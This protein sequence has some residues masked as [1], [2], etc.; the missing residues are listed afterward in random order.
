MEYES[1]IGH[2]FVNV[3]PLHPGHGTCFHDSVWHCDGV[4]SVH[5]TLEENTHYQSQT[6]LQ[7]KV[8]KAH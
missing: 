6:V 2:T 8:P 4:D 1:N 5:D 3:H 7:I